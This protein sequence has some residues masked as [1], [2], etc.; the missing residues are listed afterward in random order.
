MHPDDYADDDSHLAECDRQAELDAEEWALEV[1]YLSHQPPDETERAEM[2][3]DEMAE[4]LLNDGHEPPDYTPDPP[5]LAELW[6]PAERAE[7]A[8]RLEQH[9]VTITELSDVRERCGLPRLS[10]SSSKA[11]KLAHHI[12]ATERGRAVLAAVRAEREALAAERG[13][14][15]SRAARMRLPELRAARRAA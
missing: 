9:G 1:W 5:T 12:L 2:A 13:L 6:P 10:E 7:L 3:A 4:A 11:R 8:R 14:S 15:P